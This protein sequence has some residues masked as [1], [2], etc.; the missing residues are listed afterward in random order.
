MDELYFRYGLPPCIDGLLIPY[1]M[2][3]HILIIEDEREIAELVE[4]SLARAHFTAR[5]APTAEQARQLLACEYFDL[6]LLDVGLPHR[7]F[8]TA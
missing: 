7:R 6:L 1:P 5:I 2:N 8:R 4:L 3:P